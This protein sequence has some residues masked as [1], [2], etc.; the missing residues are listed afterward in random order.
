MKIKTVFIVLLIIVILS[1]SILIF[2]PRQ[3]IGGARDRFGCLTS[4]GYSWDDSVGACLREWELN[5]SQR[6]AAKFVVAPLSFPVTIIEVKILGCYNC[7]NVA[8]QRND[9]QIII[10]QELHDWKF[11]D[12]NTHPYFECPENCLVCPPCEACSALSC[13]TEDFCNSIGFNRTWSEQIK[14][15][16]NNSQ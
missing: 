8:Y 5:D 7:F 4:A 16:L 11:V 2:A 12:C 13:Q 3:N 6:Q 9:D 15:G 14:K 1:S 10:H